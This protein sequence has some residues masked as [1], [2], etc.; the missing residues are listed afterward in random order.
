I[1]TTVIAMAGSLGLRVVAEGVELEE[2]LA[3]LRGHRCDLVQGYL[4]GAPMP[5]AEL[6]ALMDRED[7]VARGGR[8]TTRA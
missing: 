2:Q 8:V 1:V 7:G 5:P 4:F 6:V 3:F